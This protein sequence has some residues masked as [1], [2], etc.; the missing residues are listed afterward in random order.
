LLRDVY[1]SPHA[2]A[3]IGPSRTWTF[4]DL[5][6]VARTLATELAATGVSIGSRVVLILHPSPD[7]VALEMACSILGAA[8]VPVSPEMPRHRAE[9]IIA[10]AE[11][12]LVVIP[13]QPAPPLEVATGRAGLATL[14]AASLTVSRAPPPVRASCSRKLLETDPAYIIF[15]SG[16]TGMPKGIVMSHGA[17]VSALLGADDLGIDPGGRVSTVAPLQFDFSILDMGLSLAQGSAL[18]PVPRLLTFQPAAMVDYLLKQQVTQIDCVPSVLRS[19]MRAPGQLARLRAIKTIVYGGEGFSPA[20][21]Q[22]LQDELPTTRIIQA[23]GHSESIWCCFAE[24]SRPAAHARGRVSI[25][26][27][28]GQ[29]EMFLIDDDGMEING[30]DTVGEL[31]I[32]GPSLFSGYW[33]DPEATAMR[34]V[35]DFRDSEGQGRV[36]RSGD[37][38]FRDGEGRFYFWGRKDTQVKVAGNRL[39]LEEVEAV[40]EGD[41][42]V[43]RAIA[44]LATSHERAELVAFV[45]GKAGSPPDQKALQ[46]RCGTRLPH[47]AVPKRIVVV[48]VLPTTV[49]GKVDRRRLLEATAVVDAN[50]EHGGGADGESRVRSRIP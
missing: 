42:A 26:R 5:D 8:F 38:V 2:P 37:L 36:F 46:Q 7:A 13:G 35:N 39:E 20:E 11:P 50:P 18:V 47:Y 25:G 28:L 49:N 1:R 33:R 14:L 19:I 48:T 34:L 4:A 44:A 10:S 32:R 31:Y 40:L 45:V 29:M 12:T 21:I 41:P 27:A 9:Q 43:E 24:L 16:S 6:S 30:A 3:L 23:F 22:L 15:T 17:A